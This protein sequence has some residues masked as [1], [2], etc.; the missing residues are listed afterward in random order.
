MTERPLSFQY[1]GCIKKRDGTIG[2]YILQVT[3]TLSDLTVEILVAPKNLAS[4]K[5]F[6]KTLLDQQI[7]YSSCQREHEKMLMELFDRKPSTT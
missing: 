7:L 1:S 2:L 4:A 3:E 6:K 5:S